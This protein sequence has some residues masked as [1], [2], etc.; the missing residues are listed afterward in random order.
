MERSETE[1]TEFPFSVSLTTA[2]NASL[3]LSHLHLLI[4]FFASG[5]PSGLLPS[6]LSVCLSFYPSFTLPLRLAFFSVMFYLPSR[7]IKCLCWILLYT[8]VFLS[9][10]KKISQ[11][12]RQVL[13][14][15]PVTKR[16]TDNLLHGLSEITHNLLTTAS[17]TFNVNN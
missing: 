12:Y 10:L 17:F 11:C 9:C 4:F 16:H 1:G 2:V 13:N 3:L 7:K 8:C 14:P 15:Q 6:F 5:L